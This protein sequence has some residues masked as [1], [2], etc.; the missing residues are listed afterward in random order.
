MAD[1]PELLAGKSDLLYLKQ[2]LGISSDRSHDLHGVCPLCGDKTA[3]QFGLSKDGKKSGQYFFHCHACAA[4]GSVIDALMK[5]RGMALNDACREV[6]QKYKGKSPRKSEY[7][8]YHEKNTAA[9]N[10]NGKVHEPEIKYGSEHT[11]PILSADAE[12]FVQKHH[13]YLMKR[14][15]LHEKWRRGISE[16]VCKKYRIGFIE[17]EGIQFKPWS[18]PATIPAAWVLP[19]TDGNGVLKGVK[20]HFE[21]RIKRYDGTLAAK[22]MWCPFGTEPAYDKEKEIS[23][24]H[25]Y[26]GMWPHP[27]TLT[28][29]N[30]SVET[31]DIGYWLRKM[32]PQLKQ[33]WETQLQGYRYI[34]ADEMGLSETDLGG[35]ASYEAIS[36]TFTEMGPEIQ[37]AVCKIE[38]KNTIYDDKTP[39]TDWSKFIF[40]CP[41]ELKA[42]AME[43]CGFMSTASTG[44]EQWLPGPQWISK[45]SR[46]M[47]C[48]FYDA[49]PIKKIGSTE[50]IQCTGKDW[51]R[52][53]NVALVHHG[54]AQVVAI[55]GGSKEKE[56]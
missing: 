55:N 25:S 16:A 12:A 37:E 14:P 10:G 26:Y 2:V 32:P 6:Y 42:L 20:L 17:H 30:N 52:K 21:E 3:F 15:F 31:Q 46:Q 51:A 11:D 4:N 50:K 13:E 22:L 38:N 41:G 34:V 29:P 9:H 8:V 39:E 44:G 35:P 36:R 48:L 1:S 24:V 47:C 19:I 54:A 56:Q 43:S 18:K 7:T 53:W 49:D 45:F 23:P 5:T 28:P 33:K 27:D 40:I